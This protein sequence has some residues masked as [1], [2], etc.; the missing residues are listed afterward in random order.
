[1]GLGCS[2]KIFSTKLSTTQISNV[3]SIN[4]KGQRGGRTHGKKWEISEGGEMGWST[5]GGGGGRRRGRR[6]GGR[7]WGHRGNHDAP[8]MGGTSGNLPALTGFCNA[9]DDW[10]QEKNKQKAIESCQLR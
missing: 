1:M 2:T 3:W 6:S 9:L 8:W 5:G 10:K 4:W 7:S